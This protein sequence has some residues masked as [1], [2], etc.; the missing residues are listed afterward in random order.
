MPP[1]QRAK[2]I[3]E[4]ADEIGLSYGST[5]RYLKR[6]M[7]ASGPARAKWLEAHCKARVKWNGGAG[8]TGAD[9]LV[10]QEKQVRI[11]SLRIKVKQQELE[12]L[13]DQGELIEREAVERTWSLHINDARSLLESIPA[14]VGQEIPEGELRNRVVSAAEVIVENALKALAEGRRA[15]DSE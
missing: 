15:G 4:I 14:A 9:S 11:D 3:H 13:R 5:Q 6:G 2:S 10:D 12:Y 1:R 7:P 8:G